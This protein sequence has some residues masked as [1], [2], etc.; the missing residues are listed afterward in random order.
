MDGQNM[1]QMPAPL[2]NF[3]FD[4]S[5]NS[6]LT[7]VNSDS[8]S[9]HGNAT[10]PRPKRESIESRINRLL[11]GANA[12]SAVDA[13][14]EDWLPPASTPTGNRPAVRTAP[15]FQPPSPAKS[16]APTSPPPAAAASQNSPVVSLNLD[17]NNSKRGMRV[18]AARLPGVIP[19]IYTS[20][21]AVK[22]APNLPPG[23]DYFMPRGVS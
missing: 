13:K 21:N 23:N 8:K 14:D 2:T 4:E 11:R 3:D 9:A 22:P 10:Y 15:K 18:T 1:T 6:S 19:S 20:T 17:V 12:P 5:S 7:L 16:S